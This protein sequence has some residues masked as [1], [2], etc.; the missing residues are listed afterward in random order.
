M[1][2]SLLDRLK[3]DSHIARAFACGE[4]CTRCE[5]KHLRTVLDSKERRKAAEGDT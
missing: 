4:T 1:T 5:A 2:D 3:R